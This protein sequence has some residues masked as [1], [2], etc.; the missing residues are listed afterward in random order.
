MIKR[1]SKISVGENLRKVFRTIIISSFIIYVLLFFTIMSMYTDYKNLET[2]SL[3][4]VNNISIARNAS[5]CTQN[6][7]YKMC[8][9]KEKEQQKQFNDEADSYDML[10]QE[11][12]SKIAEAKPQYKKNISEI[13][14]IQQD[15]F[16]YRSQAI[17]LGSQ[18]RKQEAIELLAE[19]YFDK[20]QSIDDILQEITN[21][22][23]SQLKSHIENVEKGILLLI[24]L[25][26]AL[27]GVTIWHCV[28]RINKVIKSIQMPLDEI[29]DAMEE[30]HRGNLNFS[31]AY[32][33]ENELGKLADR[34]RETGEQLKIYVKNID[35]VLGELSQKNFHVT[36]DMEY[37]GMFNPIEQS[38]KEIILV[39][40]SV[41]ESIF[42]TSQMVTFSAKNISL[43]ADEM[44]EGAA[45]QASATEE[46]LS[47]IRT[48]S[49]DVEKNA[50]ETFEVYEHSEGVKKSIVTSKDKMSELI[51]TMSRMLESSKQIFEIVSIIENIAEQTKLLSFNAAIEAARAGD[52][53]NGFSVVASEIKKL[54]DSTSEAA[55]RTK[56]LIHKSN[57]IVAEGNEKV[58]EISKSFEHVDHAVGIVSE[59]SLHV[60]K[61]S[62]SHTNTLLE[63]ELVIQSISAVVQNK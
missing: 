46:L 18:E 40:H 60:S 16:I 7:V 62:K 50:E 34:V 63:L 25:L 12:L 8:L 20:M 24:L 21:N 29:G 5:L 6:A 43:I 45:T 10:I 61:V 15:A 11:Y 41:M 13:K 57:S 32:Q 2:S 36:V 42:N 9:S 14:Q 3:V 58:N 27:I 1:Q 52:S 59:K 19:N 53:G 23:N 37:K 44:T 31:L 22:T 54:A 51:S 33:S 35:N 56:H 26:L 30:V 39:L 49:C 38:M 17:L 55:N 47:Y 4:M 48:I 28:I